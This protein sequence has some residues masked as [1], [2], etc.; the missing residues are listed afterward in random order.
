MRS[1]K[2][3]KNTKISVNKIICRTVGV[4]F[5]LT[6]LSAWLTCGLYAKYIVADSFEDSASVQKTGISKI[7]L[8]ENEV[9]LIDDPDEAVEKDRIYDFIDKEKN[10][11]EYKV[12]PGVEIPKNPF[13]RITG[14]TPASSDEPLVS[15]NLYLKVIE[16][17][18]PDTVIYEILKDWE[19]VGEKGTTTTYK[20]KNAIDSSFSGKIYVLKDN[21]IKVKENYVDN[22]KP[23]SLSFEAWIKQIN[24]G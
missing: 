6:M 10:G 1:C 23:F 17:N 14:S 8:I 19:I 24:Q 18:I 15:Y 21:K 5:V 16:E 2:H 22:G 9:E 13:I 4:L 12:L 11:N 20:Y 3:L 7:E